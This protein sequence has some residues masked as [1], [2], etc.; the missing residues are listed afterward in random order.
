MKNTPIALTFVGDMLV[1]YFFGAVGSGVDPDASPI[2]RAATGD[3]SRFSFV[4]LTNAPSPNGYT[5]L[6]I[7]ATPSGGGSESV[8]LTYV[9]KDSEQLVSWEDDLSKFR[10]MDATPKARRQGA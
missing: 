8:I 3:M 2:Y 4:Q 7:I 9:Q 6:S 10:E 5:Q 1:V